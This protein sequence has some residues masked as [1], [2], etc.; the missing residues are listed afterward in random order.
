VVSS[1][2]PYLRQTDLSNRVFD[3]YDAIIDA[4]CEAWNR[5]IDKPW[6]IMSI[7]MW[8][9]AYAGQSQ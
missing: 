9:W 7:G 6:M 2:T 3:S 8:D 1:C 5:L 4:A